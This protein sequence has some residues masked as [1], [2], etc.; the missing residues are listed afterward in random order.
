MSV[1]IV[2]NSTEFLPIRCRGSSCST[3]SP[4]TL[5]GVKAFIELKSLNIS[6]T[7]PKVQVT[8]SSP[9]KFKCNNC[10]TKFTLSPSVL[11]RYCDKGLD[12]CPTCRTGIRNAKISHTLKLKNATGEIPSQHRYTTKSYTKELA[13]RKIKPIEEYNGMTVSIEHECLVCDHIFKNSPGNVI[14]QNCGCSVCAGKILKTHETYLLELEEVDTLFHPVEDYINS[15]TR[16]KH[17]CSVCDFVKLAS[18]TNILKGGNTANYCPKHQGSKGFK[19]NIAKFGNREIQYQGYN[20]LALD[21]LTK[22]EG[23]K[24]KDIITEYESGIPVVRYRYKGL[25]RHYPDIYIK[26]QRLAIEVKSTYTLGLEK[27][28]AKASSWYVQCAKAKGATAQGLKYRLM[29]LTDKGKEIPIPENWYQYSFK[30]IIQ[31]ISTSS[32]S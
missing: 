26:S 2:C 15:R 23:F 19:R 21:I 28:S 14:H 16:I 20:M 9:I 7:R 18:P 3:C 1:C 5:E 25:K 12:V 17:K 11:E 10:Y 13:K 30:E 8:R 24:A 29:I 32:P 4:Q 31:Y 6:M 27:R 22:V